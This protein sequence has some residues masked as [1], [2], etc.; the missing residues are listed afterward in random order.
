MQNLTCQR[1]HFLINYNTALNLKVEPDEY[2]NLI[3][4]V[5]DKTGLVILMV[6]LLDFPCS[7]WPEM[8]ELI[9]KNRPIFLVGNKVDLLPKDSQEYLKHVKRRLTDSV[10]ESGM[11]KNILC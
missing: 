1:C 10:V 11:L 7:I 9:G 5:K 4:S 3:S 2:L 6:D 8:L